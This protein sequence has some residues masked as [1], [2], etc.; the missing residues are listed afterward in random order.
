MTESQK[1]SNPAEPG[2]DRSELLRGVVEALLRELKAGAA[3]KDKR[4]Q[5]EEWM[6]SLAEKYPDFAIEQGLR[7][8]Y[9]A[10]AERLRADFDAATDLG[11]RL[12]LGRA[13]EGFLDR[14]ADYQRRIGSR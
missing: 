9:L 10:E 7:D 12:S 4:R 14:A 2:G 5:V 8:Y 13:V 6:R 1:A 3:D 11:E